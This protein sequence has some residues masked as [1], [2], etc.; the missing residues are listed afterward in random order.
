M[1]GGRRF[2]EAGS[3]EL[4]VACGELAEG[5]SSL[6]EVERDDELEGWW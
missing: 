3:R 4:G 2:G 6:E 5:E 1:A